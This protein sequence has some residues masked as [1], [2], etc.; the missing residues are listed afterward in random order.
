MGSSDGAAKALP[1]AGIRVLEFCH[2][3]MGP[4]CGLVLAD[5]GAEVIKIEPVDGDRTRRLSGFAA[6]FFATFNRNKRCLAIDLKAPEGRAVIERLLTETDI[7]IENFAPGTMERL[8]LGYEDLS[9][10]Y[11]RLIYGALKGFLSGPYEHRPALDEVVQYMSGLA[12]MTGPSGRPLRAGASVCDILG[13]VLGVVGTLAALQERGRTGKG[14]LVKSALF[15]AATFLMS[16]HMMGEVLTGRPM[17][18]MPERHGAWAIYETFATSDDRQF[19]LGLT[20]D[21]HW[22]RF[23]DLFMRPDLLA[24][25]S[26][27]SNEDRVAARPRLK[28]I[29]AE[30]IASH[31]HDQ[32][33]D[34]CE[35]NGLP[36]A[37]VMRPGDLKDDPQLNAH[38]RMLEIELEG[39]RTAKLPRLPIEMGDHDTGLRSQPGR[40]GEHTL[41]ILA[42]LGIPDEESAALVER[43][44][45]GG[46]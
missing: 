39:G 1:L 32:M 36:F 13:G 7:V 20:S 46:P 15:E 21:N 3:I 44:I 22:R 30:I 12:Y 19:F 40:I 2:V 27:A 23:C 34:M 11:P 17:P 37:P 33:A 29:V 43:G 31:T 6:G 25:P 10:R 41:A 35:R 5:L 45:V 28:P 9:A 18:P 8:G 16:S 4:S 26:L 24:D 38:D 42:E 14:Q